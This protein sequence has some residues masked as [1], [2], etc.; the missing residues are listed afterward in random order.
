M[1][2]LCREY[3]ISREAGYKW[4]KRFQEQGY[5]GLNELSRRPLSAPLSTGEEI[6]VAL[7]EAKEKFPTFGP[8]KI[9]TIVGRKFSDM[10]S[11]AT[12][13]RILKRL[14]LVTARKRRRAL[15]AVTTVPVI[16]AMRSNEVW[17][18]DFKGY[19]RTLDNGKCNPLTVRDAFS[20]FILCIQSLEHS[21][22]SL[23]KKEMT[24]LFLKYGLPKRIHC[25]NGTPFI[26]VRARGGIS[27]LT[28]WWISLGIEVIRSRP[29]CPQ[30][31]GSHERMHKDVAIQVEAHPSETV[32]AEQRALSKFQHEYNHIR[33]HDALKS[34]TPAEVYKPS[35]LTH[36]PR[37]VFIYPQAWLPLSVNP[38]GLF[39]MNGENYYIG[40]GL[41]GQ[42][43]ALD[44]QDPEEFRFPPALWVQ[45]VYDFALAYHNQTLH[46][47]HML[48]ALTPLYLGRTASFVLETQ[49]GDSL[50][51]ERTVETL[52][53]EF[54]V[55][56]SYLVEQWRWRDE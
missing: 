38:K 31:N 29:G 30:D 55:S 1:A 46:R 19:W 45:T 43:I 36:L 3:G 22:F 52:C 17:T 18:I 7:L 35:P 23:V 14:G 37:K 51:V 25:D 28:A 8:D 34:K 42:I 24:K 20:R 5:D 12:V 26:A 11:R 50:E 48:K 10:P 4:L 27:K 9:R 16:R 6:V 39:R 40:E 21:S 41:A 2:V 15:S 13:T 47:E 53:R 49:H 56:K 32:V 54:E 33:P 44:I